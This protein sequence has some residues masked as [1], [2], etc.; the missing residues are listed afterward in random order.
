MKVGASSQPFHVGP[1]L[2]LIERT[3]HGNENQSINLVQERLE[4]FIFHVV[5]LSDGNSSP[6]LRDVDKP[7]AP[8]IALNWP[9]AANSNDLSIFCPH[10]A[11]NPGTSAHG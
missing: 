2:V 5:R 10:V 1:V 4:E 6:G 3:V 8:M 7:A 11:N 9:E